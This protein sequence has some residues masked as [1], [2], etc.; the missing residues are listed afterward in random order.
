MVYWFHCD[1]KEDNRWINE[2]EWDWYFTKQKDGKKRANISKIQEDDKTIF[3]KGLLAYADGE[4]GKINLEEGNY[5]YDGEIYPYKVEYSKITTWNKKVP[6]FSKAVKRF[7]A[8]VPFSKSESGTFFK[9]KNIS[10][11]DITLRLRGTIQRINKEIFEEIKNR[12]Q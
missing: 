8:N 4:I 5:P 3:V 9:N 6:L 7:L 1:Y 10:Q 11:N 2:P 12:G